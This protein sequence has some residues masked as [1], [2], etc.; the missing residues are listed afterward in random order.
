MH[1]HVFI[2]FQSLFMKCVFCHRPLQNKL[3][4]YVRRNCA[5]FR[6][7]SAS[8]LYKTETAWHVTSR[9]CS[10]L[11]SVSVKRVPHYIM[12]VGCIFTISIQHLALHSYRQY[13]WS[14][15]RSCVDK[16]R[17]MLNLETFL[18]KENSNSVPA[19]RYFYWLTLSK[20]TF[21]LQPPRNEIKTRSH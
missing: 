21:Q 16:M 18:T 9:F 3:I 14:H 17:N 10:Q 8:N 5:K 13:L 7:C 2:T 1:R 4:S 11:N 19:E 6:W 15:Y 12:A 20:I